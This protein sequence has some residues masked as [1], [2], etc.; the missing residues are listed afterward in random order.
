MFLRRSHHAGP[1]H[2][3]LD[4]WLLASFL[5]AA[6]ATPA[7]ANRPDPLG[8]LVEEAIQANLSL[9]GERLAE[10]ASAAEVQEAIGLYLPRVDL[11]SRYSDVHGVQNLGNLINP[12]YAALNQLTGTNSFPTDIDITL[13]QRHDTHL[14]LSQPLLAEGIRANVSAA[15]ARHDAQ[16]LELGAS[17][18]R[19]AALVQLAYLQEASARRVVE[20]QEAALDLVRENE[21]TAERLVAAGRA[22]PEAVLR[23]RADRAEVQ[24]QLDESRE[25]D[26]AATRELNRILRRPL[27]T[28]V[29][30]VPDDV[31]D[32]PLDVDADSAVAHAL[33][34]REELSA[35]DAG[36]RVAEAAKRAVTSR[37]LPSVSF[38][39]DYGFQGQAFEFKGE[40]DY[41][42]AS[43]VA[44]WELVG[45][46]R[47]GARSAAGYQV[48][49]ARTSRA[50]LADQIQVEVRTAYEAASVAKAAIA[51]ADTRRDAARR[52]FELVR[53]R[54]D[55][56]VA[57]PVELVDARTTFTSA[58]LNRVLTAYRY[59]MR[60][61]DLERAAA[62]RDL[63]L[64]P[65]GETP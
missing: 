17:A 2:R 6:L 57:S 37:F 26:V 21:R 9:Q 8:P 64:S 47:H 53:R 33:T 60:W 46:S 12:A 49:R 36:V 3:R 19:I 34:S 55:E 65:K 56:G 25:R 61:V 58:E 11:E 18:R 35:G 1:A 59:A 48:E 20:I 10:R 42:M 62:L 7:I 13:P 39:L 51:T 23:A 28:P 5:V 15:R 45:A 27:D 54:Y 16:R 43:L 40:E 52:T 32:L 44:Q 14:R 41:W 63:S 4:V 31:F 22:T 29:F 24:Q 38:A 50:D 30:V